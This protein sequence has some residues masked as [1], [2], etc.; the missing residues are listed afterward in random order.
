MEESV[1]ITSNLKNIMVLARRKFLTFQ[2]N[3][4][5]LKTNY[6]T[7]E[8][9]KALNGSND[10]NVGPPN[11]NRIP[12][13]LSWTYQALNLFKGEK[14]YSFI[15]RIRRE[16]LRECTF[17]KA[18]KLCADELKYPS[19]MGRRIL[20]L[21]T[22]V[23]RFESMQYGVDEMTFPSIHSDDQL[24]APGG[25]TQ[26]CIGKYNNLITRYVSWQRSLSASRRPCYSRRYRHEICIFGLAD[27]STKQMGSHIDA[28]RNDYY[29]Q[30]L[31]V[32]F[33][34]EK[35]KWRQ[36]IEAFDCDA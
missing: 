17:T 19:S 29:S 20:N 2:N 23:D 28:S 21:T 8:I 7:V 12:Q 32:R 30:R 31:P 27:L 26:H 36:N 14:H 34:N 11:K 22:L 6:E 24:D 5:P 33:H 16:K 3:D 13:N 18:R 9:L 10:I 1:L 35:A 4:I 15:T 25:F